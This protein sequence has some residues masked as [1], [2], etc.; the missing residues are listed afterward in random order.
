MV[1]DT[2]ATVAILRMEAEADVFLLAI[3]RADPCFMSAVSVEEASLVLAGRR[4]GPEAWDELDAF[5]ERS[6][7]Q[8]VPFD[9]GLARLARNAFIRFGKGRHGAA[10][11]LGD[12]AS[13]ALAKERDLPLLFKGNDFAKTDIAPAVQ[14]PKA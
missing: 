9:R 7:I 5:L 2:S 10:L 6:E 12:C 14:T 1:V 3:S 13:Y 11:N 4:G 8:V